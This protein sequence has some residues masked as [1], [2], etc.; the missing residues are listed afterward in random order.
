MLSG[1][2]RLKHTSDIKILVKGETLE[3]LFSNALQAMAKILVRGRLAGRQCQANIKVNSSEETSLLIDF[4]SEVL[5]LSAKRGAVFDKVKFR[6]LDSCQL[7]AVVLGY[8]VDRFDKDIKA[9]TYHEAQIKRNKKGE[10]ET[11]VIFD[12]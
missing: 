9:V 11:V 5:F 6:Y 7:S 12:L 8:K 10:L 3:N 2:R 4:L 1:Y